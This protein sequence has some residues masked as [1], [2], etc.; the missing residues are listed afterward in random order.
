MWLSFLNTHN[1]V[2]VFR[3]QLWV[4]TPDLELFTDAAGS[5][6]MGIYFKGK[7]AQ[8]KWGEF[9]KEE[10][11]RNNITFLEFFPILVALHLFGE[12][13]KNKRV[14]FHCDN[15]AVVEIINQQ[16]CKCPR[17]IYL[18]SPMVLRCTELNTEIKAKHIKG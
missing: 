8:A 3:D 9:F 10:A 5:I 13:L 7:W 12:E 11:N 18:V 6:G 15:I 4:S 14:V 17:V 2:S 1:G 16:T